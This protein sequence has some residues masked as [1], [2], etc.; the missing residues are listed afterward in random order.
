M[1]SGTDQGRNNIIR[2]QSNSHS[3]ILSGV[4]RETANTVE[5]QLSHLAILL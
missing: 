3:I 4:S 5:G 2:S 1:M